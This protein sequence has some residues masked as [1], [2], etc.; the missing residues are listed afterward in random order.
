VLGTVTLCLGVL[1]GLSPVG[2]HGVAAAAEIP[3]P[4]GTLNVGLHIELLHNDWQATVAHPF[5]HVMGHVF[6]GLTAF[7][8]NF[9]PV[10]EL[11]ESIDPG[12]GGTLWTFKLRKGVLFHNGKEMGAADVQAS[13]ERWRRVGPKGTIFKNLERFEIADKYTLR[14]HFKEPIGRSLLLALGSD[15]NK[16]IIMPKE[17]AEASPEATKLSEVIGTGP[18]RFVENKPDQFIRLKRFDRYV[19]RT[20]PPNYQGGKKLTYMNEIIFWIIVPGCGL[21]DRRV[22]HHH[23]YSGHGIYAVQG[24]SRRRPREER[25]RALGVHD[26]QSQ[27]GADQQPLYPQGDSDSSRRTRDHGCRDL[28]RGLSRHRSQLLPAGKSVQQ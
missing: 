11:A 2:T 5:P 19:P 28:Q 6:E 8:K 24:H 25:P 7:G 4:G 10:P 27:E 16:A 18:Y 21:G 20:D 9:D 14:M 22:R 17:I 23:R 26:V 12:S 1:F 15:E 13:L 3:K